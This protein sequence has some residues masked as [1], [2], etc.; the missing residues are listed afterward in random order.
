MNI[1]HTETINLCIIGNPNLELIMVR[2]GLLSY[3]HGGFRAYEANASS[4]P[5]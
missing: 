1:K 2:H 3:K 5:V 4:K